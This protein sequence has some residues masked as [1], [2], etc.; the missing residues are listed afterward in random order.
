MKRRL[1]Y[2]LTS[3]LLFSC[4][5]NAM[6]IVYPKTNNVEINSDSTFFIGNENP[7]S[8]LTINSQPVDIHSTGGFLYPVNLN[9]G[10]NLF[11]ISNGVEE[12][13]YKIIR[14]KVLNNSKVI[15]EISYKHPELYTINSSNVPLRSTPYDYGI[16]RLQ[17]LEKGIPLSVVGEYGDFYKVQ[18]ARD[19]YAWVAKSDVIKSE[20]AI[21]T[22]KIESFIYNEECGKRVFTIKL[23]KKVPYILSESSGLDLVVYNVEGYPENKYEFHIN[24]TGELFGY[25]SYYKNNNELVIEVKNKPCV[26]KDN[27]LAGLKI[28]LDAGHGGK[29]LG[30]IGCLEDK[31]KD[32]NLSVVLKLKNL[33]EDAGAVVYLTRENDIEVS[34]SDRVKFSQGKDSDIF[35]SIHNN[36]LPDSQAF[37]N[38]SGS[39]V[40][41]FYPQSKVLGDKILNSLLSLGLAN[42]KLRRESFAVVRNTESLAVLVEIGYMINPEDNAKITNEAF[43]LQAA[44]AI[45]QGLEN[46]FNGL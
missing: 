8:A 45:K 12:K 39:S 5:S 36:A 27:L 18:L 30:A 9:E 24:K 13:V 10:E 35:I 33:L 21:S 42:D 22:A 34:L 16:N 17:H 2:L 20:D 32:I 7:K 44:Q 28:T 31:E 14:K 4:S 41:Y 38:R 15:K 1:T 11:V 46:Y 26:S 23:N 29:E 25:R 19:D 37:S 3:L 40:F 43:Q 6:D